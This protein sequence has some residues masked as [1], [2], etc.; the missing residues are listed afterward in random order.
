MASFPY[1]NHFSLSY[2]KVFALRQLSGLI[3]V[4]INFIFLKFFFLL[5]K[6]KFNEGII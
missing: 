2:L 3:S 6:I 4:N 1:L 5:R